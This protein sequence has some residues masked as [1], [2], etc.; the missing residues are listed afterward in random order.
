M[1]IIDS[2]KGHMQQGGM[3]IPNDE[4]TRENFPTLWTVLTEGRVDGGKEIVPAE[5]KIERV[6]GGYRVTIQVH[7]CWLLKRFL[8]QT[9]GELETAAEIAL[10]SSD[11]PWERFKSYRQKIDPYKAEKKSP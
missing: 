1:S 6:S 11:V 9:L 4:E 3:A 8:I 10:N 2:L 7:A 5:I